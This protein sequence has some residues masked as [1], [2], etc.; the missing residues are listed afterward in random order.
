MSAAGEISSSEHMR[1]AMVLINAQADQD[2]RCP[3]QKHWELEMPQRE[4]S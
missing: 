4:G 3:L 1:T 2:H